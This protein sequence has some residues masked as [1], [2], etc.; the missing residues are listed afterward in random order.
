MDMTF[1]HR[2]ECRRLTEFPVSES[3]PRY[4]YPGAS[5]EGGRDGVLVEVRPDGGQAWVGVFAFGRFA[6][7]GVSGIFATPDADRL[8]VVTRGEGYVVSASDPSSWERVRATPVTEVRP[9]QA[10]GILLLASF[11][12]LF[13]YGEAGLLWRT[14]R[15]VLDGLRIREITETFVTG[16]GDAP[17]RGTATFCVDLRTG[18]RARAEPQR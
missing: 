14:E 4:C 8:C 15:L 13:A 16:E 3:V 11:T 7:V 18:A 6:Q 5:R 9:L 10:Q 2:Y 17:G 1:P 12:D